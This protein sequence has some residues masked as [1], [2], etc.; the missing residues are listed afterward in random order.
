[1]FQLKALFV[2]LYLLAAVIISATCLV[3]LWQG[4]FVYLG[5]LL[6]WLPLPLI[7]LLR[8]RRNVAWGEERETPLMLPALLGLGCV[9]LTEQ[10]FS[11]PLWL[12]L[13]GLFALLLYFFVMTA[14]PISDRVQALVGDDAQARLC[15]LK[16]ID[17]RGEAVCLANDPAR[18]VLFVHSAGPYSRMAI[19]QLQQVL[20]E[21]VAILKPEQVVLISSSGIESLC[22]YLPSGVRCWQD[23]QGQSLEAL[24]LLL[25]GGNWPLGDAVR[26]ALAVVD[27]LGATR[28][29]S[30]ADNHRLAP[31][32]NDAWPR[33]ERALTAR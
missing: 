7:Q 31:C 18:L 15:S 30:V 1:M 2:R 14:T 23:T 26:P 32:L 12:A 20:V 16:F 5:V 8:L 3:Q 10:H 9:L 29:W 27:G 28:F 22:K 25:R 11:A 33:L 19:R 21:R 17:E 24:G 6:M 13:A 4:S